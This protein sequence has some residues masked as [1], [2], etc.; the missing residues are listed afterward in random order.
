[1]G[2]VYDRAEKHTKRAVS[3]ILLSAE[4]WSESEQLAFDTCKKSLAQR[5]TL[6]HRDTSQWLCIYTN[7]SDTACSG[8]ITQVPS[9]DVSKP[10]KNQR[11]LPLLLLSGQF[12][13]TELVRSAL[14]K[15]AFVVLNTLDRMHLLET[16]LEG[17]DL[18]IDHNNVILLFD[19]LSVILDMSQTTL[20][21]FLR[22]AVWLS[23][24]RCTRYHIKAKTACG[25]TFWP[26]DH[27]RVRLC[28]T[29]F[30][31][32]AFPRPAQK[33][34]SGYLRPKLEPYR[35][36]THQLAQRNC[37]WRTAFTCIRITQFGYQMALLTYS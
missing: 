12:N 11:H 5:V 24:Y 32:S 29:S 20:R 25:Q 23:I 18:Y 8:I 36:N 27:L 17:F 34:S 37:P 33:L 2:R 3:R 15:E 22:W 35:C 9:H 31:I 7:A 6:S 1:M 19:P 14:K 16:R 10:L 4:D 30:N 13:A 28:D 21:K 26:V